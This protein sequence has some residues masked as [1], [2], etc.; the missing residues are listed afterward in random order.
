MSRTTQNKGE[1]VDEG[2][3]NPLIR[4]VTF[5]YYKLRLCE[6]G[7]FPLSL[8]EMITEILMIITK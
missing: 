3:C 7:K 6:T 4:I 5:Q 2:F 8:I 1:V